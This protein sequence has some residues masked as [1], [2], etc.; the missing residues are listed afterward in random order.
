MEDVRTFIDRHG[1]VP[2]ADDQF[3]YFE[4]TS[5]ISPK[6]SFGL[7]S[8]AKDEFM[9]LY[10]S[11][12]QSGSTTLGITE[13]MTGS[14]PVVVDIDLSIASKFLQGR[15]TLYTLDH[16]VGVA[17]I[18]QNALSDIGADVKPEHLVAI[19]LEKPGYT[20][21][22]RYKNG[23]HL[24]FPNF[25]ME[26]H[27]YRDIL[28]PRVLSELETSDLLRDVFTYGTSSLQYKYSDI[29]DSACF[30]NPWLM[31]GSR[32]SIGAG[33]YTVTGVVGANRVFIRG[34]EAV[35]TYIR[36]CV[37]VRWPGSGK[38]VQLA[39]N[40]IV[41]YYFPL[42]LSIHT[43][44]REA[45]PIRRTVTALASHED[46]IARARRLVQPQSY[47]TTFED[48]DDATL[49][50]NV[51]DAAELVSMIADSRADDYHDWTRIGWAIYTVSNGSQ[52]GFAVWSA[53]SSRSY[54]YDE[55]HCTKFWTDSTS[56]GLLTM[57]T[58]RYYAKMDSPTEYAAWVHARTDCTSFRA[59]VD[60]AEDYSTH[61][62]MSECM[63]ES[64]RAKYVCASVRHKAW[65]EYT[66]HRWKVMD[67]DTSLRN[68]VTPHAAEFVK[69]M[70][71]RIASFVPNGDAVVT[72]TDDGG[73]ESVD[74]IK[75]ILHKLVK[76]IEMQTKNDLFKSGVMREAQC[77]FYDESFSTKL[78]ADPYIIGCR[79]GVLD[80]K[81]NTFREG[82]P[83]DYISLQMNVEFKEFADDDL[84]VKQVE[85]F[86]EQIL[87]DPTVRQFFLD[88]YCDIFVGGNQHKYLCVWSGDGDNGKS[89]TEALFEKMMG[90]Y[91]VKL[92]TS[93]LTG[94]RTASSAACPELD[95]AG[96]GVRW[97][98]LQEPGHDETIN[99]GILKELSGNDTIFTRGLY[100]DGREIKPLFKIALVCNG[101]PKIPYADKAVW[102]R[103]RVIPF[104]AVFTD[105]A[106]DSYGEQLATKTFKKDRHFEDKLPGMTQ[107]LAWVLLRHRR[108]RVSK[109]LLRIIEPE[110]VMAATLVYKMRNDF[111]TQFAEESIRRCPEGNGDT[112]SIGVMS[113]YS[114]FKDWFK[115]NTTSVQ[116][117]NKLEFT[118][119]LSKAIKAQPTNGRWIG[120]TLVDGQFGDSTGTDTN[121]GEPDFMNAGKTTVIIG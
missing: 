62:G 111:Y 65:Y 40:R 106:P 26:K 86:L 30:K 114:M 94:K 92:P 112:S 6:R 87:P 103:I 58:L 47:P 5:M 46:A 75:A 44:H 118:D 76:K 29:L 61:T 17:T 74:D 117:P 4:F 60:M 88:N 116:M 12:L 11:E 98:V 38:L 93:L 1:I 100:K 28:Y 32:K 13:V 120:F 110:K 83:S 89:V 15:E 91:A 115:M 77:R 66:S 90:E 52:D 22:H 121:S 81:T 36:D 20:D 85:T 99:V 33:T 105:D 56:K 101:L 49:K 64:F 95:R 57:G 107:A 42:V 3:P 34:V 9:E 27:V 8:Q 19:V 59:L 108:M 51:K 68:H 53:F 109:G 31:Y 21:G 55:D 79:N 67:A 18:F 82:R 10:C 41:E 70:R 96:D 78:N 104:E 23:F 84:Q 7:K 80:L 48:A 16:I 2:K 72:P 45:H 54:K 14:M 25:I 43:Y 73:E 119:N 39:D 24:H 71:A 97:A 102:N 50:Q 63:H 35:C 37:P 69:D 113:V